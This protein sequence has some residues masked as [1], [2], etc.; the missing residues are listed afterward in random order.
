MP[1][2][3]PSSKEGRDTVMTFKVVL[4]R[5][6]LKVSL[7]VDEKEIIYSSLDSQGK[8]VI[9]T[10]LRTQYGMSKYKI[11]KSEILKAN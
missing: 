1:S 3:L 5:R 11:S 9:G 8:E 2:V 6:H 4:D 10:D 7:R